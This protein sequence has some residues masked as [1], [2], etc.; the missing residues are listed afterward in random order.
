MLGFIKIAAA[1]GITTIKIISTVLKIDTGSSY[2]SYR[3]RDPYADYYYP[4]F[5][6]QRNY[7]SH[8]EP[9]P[10]YSPEPQQIQAM[11]QVSRRWD[12]QFGYYY[13]NRLPQPNYNQPKP[14]NTGYQQMNT[15]NQT[16]VS[17]YNYPNGT[18]NQIATPNYAQN[19]N[20]NM[21]N[22]CMDTTSRRFMNQ[23]PTYN[24]FNRFQQMPPSQLY[25]I[26]PPPNQQHGMYQQPNQCVD[27]RM[28][29]QQRQAQNSQCVGSSKPWNERQPIFNWDYIRKYGWG[30]PKVQK[31]PDD[32]VA[33]F[34]DPEGRP[35][36]GPAVI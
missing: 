27:W 12:S 10:M 21:I 8:S 34:Y 6:S 32:V 11:P 20:N 4:R 23:N 9:Q 36:F 15:M 28:L 33:M 22:P 14:V 18:M 7:Y 30:E 19:M 1:V 3:S 29:E 26:Q 16:N 25:N 31:D 5:D 13:P 35:L 17:G 2:S 24:N